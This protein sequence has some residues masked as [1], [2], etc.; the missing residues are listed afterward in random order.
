M[1]LIDNISDAQRLARTIMSDISLYNQDKIRQSIKNDSLFEDL[2]DQLEEG[3]K[4]Y[5][6]RVD[7]TMTGRWIP[8]NRAI[9]DVLV[10]RFG[11]VDS[12]IW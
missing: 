10:K 3:R 2:A 5:D 7:P 12:D 8:Y 11:E 4:L 9:V 1:S 6:S